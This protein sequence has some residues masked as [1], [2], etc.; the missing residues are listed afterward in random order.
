MGKKEVTSLEAYYQ[1]ES[2]WHNEHIV[3][4]I[5]EVK[6]QD[7]FKDV[8]Q[9][10]ELY[11]FG[12]DCFYNSPAAPLKAIEVLDR[13]FKKAG[14]EDAQA[15]FIL[16]KLTGYIDNSGF[17]DEDITDKAKETFVTIFEAEL[18]R[19]KAQVIEL[20]PQKPLVKNI[21]ATLKTW[22]QNELEKLP[23]TLEELPAD[24]RANILCKL[25]PFVLP[26]VDSVHSER[27][28]DE[29]GEVWK[30]W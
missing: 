28:E 1:T 18:Q 21:R 19:R 6:Q 5:A 29:E 23:E 25:I 13:E 10:I 2:E 12:M 9:A 11:N 14:L 26:R 7:N 24:K 22:V 17:D 20:T 15:V 3:K 4:L 16:E 30:A 8:R 27:G